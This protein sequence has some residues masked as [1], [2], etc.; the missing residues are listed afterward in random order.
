M[1]AAMRRA[2]SRS[3]P[4]PS[5]PSHRCGTDCRQ[6]I[7]HAG[8]LLGAAQSPESMGFAGESANKLRAGCAVLF[9]EHR[10]QLAITR[11]QLVGLAPLV[12]KSAYVE[13]RHHYINAV[14]AE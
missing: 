4:K 10:K 13:E 5:G 3:C 2:Q 14:T 1:V 6:T 7:F 12:I 11:F 9:F 8:S